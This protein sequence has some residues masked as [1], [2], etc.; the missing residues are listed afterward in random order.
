[1][2]KVLN[3]EDKEFYMDFKVFILTMQGFLSTIFLKSS[4]FVDITLHQNELLYKCQIAAHSD[5]KVTL[6]QFSNQKNP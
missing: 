6:N 4:F 5:V 2:I 3:Y 1:M